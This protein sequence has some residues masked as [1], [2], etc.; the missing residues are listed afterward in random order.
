MHQTKNRHLLLKLCR[1][2]NHDLTVQSSCVKKLN[3]RC[4]TSHT[5]NVSL[6][7]RLWE[8]N[9]IKMIAGRLGRF[10]ESGN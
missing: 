9:Q 2:G 8:N 1:Q 4:V 5:Q 7:F 6:A 3:F 10:H